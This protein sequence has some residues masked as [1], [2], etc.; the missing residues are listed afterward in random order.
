ME[1][2]ESLVDQ[3]QEVQE[4]AREEHSRGKLLRTYGTVL[5]FLFSQTG[6]Y[7]VNLR[8]LSLILGWGGITL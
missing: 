1:K 6:L 7:L 5:Q 4:G 2:A 8:K 3:I